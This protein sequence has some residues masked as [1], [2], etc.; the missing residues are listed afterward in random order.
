MVP[1]VGDNC[2]LGPAHLLGV[3]SEDHVLV[4]DLK[5][6]AGDGPTA[7]GEGRSDPH[8][9][10]LGSWKG[11]GVGPSSHVES[12]VG[13]P[14]GVEIVGN[15]DDKVVIPDAPGKRRGMCFM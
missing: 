11:G 5:K 15:D 3:L 4:R 12:S 6:G 13:T 9:L 14:F 10:I 8:V 1:S 2:V 7:S